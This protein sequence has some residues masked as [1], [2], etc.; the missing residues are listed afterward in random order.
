MDLFLKIKQECSGYPENCTTEQA[1]DEYIAD[2]LK[3]QGILLDKESI[4][5]NP[6][7]RL[8]AKLFL[9]RYFRFWF[10]QLIFFYRL[11]E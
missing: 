11:G 9:N 1:K 2:Y 7:L 8:V 10:S 6:S 4:S 5:R 3:V